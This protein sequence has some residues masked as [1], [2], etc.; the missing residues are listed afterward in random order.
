MAVV[1]NHGDGLLVIASQNSAH[2]RWT[3]GFKCNAIADTKL[4]HGFV[5]THL[6]NESEAL[7]DA[8]VQVDEFGFVQI[9]N[10]DAIHTRLPRAPPSVR[11]GCVIG[12]SCDSTKAV[13]SAGM[14]RSDSF[15]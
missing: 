5:G 2:R 8:V 4:Q 12:H 14:I 3:L 6:T 9:I 13:P 10:V 7:H 1:C 15:D 11:L